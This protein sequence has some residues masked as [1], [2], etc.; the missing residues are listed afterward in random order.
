MSE[1]RIEQRLES[2]S[3]LFITS[4]ENGSPAGDGCYITDI[5]EIPEIIS[6]YEPEI[7]YLGDISIVPRAIFCLQEFLLSMTGCDWS[8]DGPA[9]KKSLVDRNTGE[10]PFLS[11]YILPERD[12][13]SVFIRFAQGVNLS[14]TAFK[15]N[16]GVRNTVIALVRI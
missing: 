13:G 1:F 7:E 2:W 14:K 11:L 5:E 4:L 15:R 6:E 12:P 9:L 3:Q 8:L 16:T 10:A